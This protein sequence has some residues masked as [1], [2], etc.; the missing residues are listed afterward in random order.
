VPERVRLALVPPSR[1]PPRRRRVV[2]LA[3][4]PE[5][6]S[7]DSTAAV[8]RVRRGLAGVA[9]QGQWP[10]EWAGWARCWMWPGVWKSC[11]RFT[12]TGSTRKLAGVLF[13]NS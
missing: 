11:A 1:A 10:G 5:H 4:A 13:D 8:R 2:N 6:C 7:R 9:A 3:A 12:I